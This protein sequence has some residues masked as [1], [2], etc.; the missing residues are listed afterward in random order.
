[1]SLPSLGRPRSGTFPAVIDLYGA[2]GG[3]MEYRASLL[4][5]HG[6]LTLA[7]AYFDYDDLPKNLGGLHLDY[8]REAVEFLRSQP[9]VNNQEIGVIGISK[10]ADLAISMATFLP[11]IK[12]VVSISGCAANSFVSLQCDGFTL[13]GLR[14]DPEKIKLTESG[15][16]DLSEAIDD[17]RDPTHE[18]CLIP[19]EKSSAAFLMLSGSDDKGWPSAAYSEQLVLRL[20]GHGKN[21]EYYCYPGTGHLLEPPN[22]P[23]CQASNNK[24]FGGPML[25]GGQP[26]DHARA[27]EA[28]WQKIQSFLSKHLM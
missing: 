21:V 7:L 9:Q 17:P 15:L 20:R 5:S 22:F 13:P 16:L 23:L 12:A 26:K 18:E 10:G 27:Q 1:M 6:F 14:F 24:H 4:A 25:W 11:G 8:F 3:L 19:A 2:G 28:A